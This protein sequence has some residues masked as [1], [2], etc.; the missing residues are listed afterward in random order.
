MLLGQ[1][2]LVTFTVEVERFFSIPCSTAAL[3]TVFC[4]GEELVVATLVLL[5]VLELPQPVIASAL[6][7][8]PLA[9]TTRHRRC[10]RT[11]KGSHGSTVLT[12]VPASECADA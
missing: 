12:S 7:A 1:L 5:E 2:A 3:F 9:T 4:V 6:S 11:P 10:C 8:R